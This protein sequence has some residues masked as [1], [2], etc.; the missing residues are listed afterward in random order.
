MASAQ[1][2]ALRQPKL[3]D[4][5]LFGVSAGGGLPVGEFKNHEDGGGGFELMFGYQPFR[6]FPLALRSHGGALIYGS[7][8]ERAVADFC[9]QY[10]YCQTEEVNYNA[11][12][13]SMW[14]LQAGPELFATEGRFRPFMFAVG[15]ITWFR[16]WANILPDNPYG[17]QRSETLFSSHNVSTAYGAGFRIVGNSFGRSS[18]FELSARVTRNAK[19]SYLT[20]EGTIK[21]A[22][23]TFTVTPRYGAANVLGIH[24]GFWLGPF[25]NWNER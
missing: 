16:S 21:N 19:A 10:G 13:H 20:E 11:R 12:D 5:F 4:Q 7:I 3:T 24:I 8:D 15:G 9:D 6:R 18:G 14:Y 25:V 22:D 2:F 23:G 1:I 17:S